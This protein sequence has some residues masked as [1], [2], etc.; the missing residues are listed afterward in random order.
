MKNVIPLS[1][2]TLDLRSLREVAK[3]GFQA[4]LSTLIK[5]ERGPFVV[6]SKFRDCEQDDNQAQ[7]T[8]NRITKHFFFSFIILVHQD[9]QI[10]FLTTFEK[11]SCT[12]VPMDTNGY[13]NVVSASLDL[14]IDVIKNNSN[15][16]CDV[17]SILNE[18]QDYFESKGLSFLFKGFIKKPQRI[19]YILDHHT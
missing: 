13:I 1:T 19:G 5:D 18:V 7:S 12:I 3:R 10:D 8:A 4:D 17:L 9:Y 2:N 11:M 16:D 6:L 14:W 15:V